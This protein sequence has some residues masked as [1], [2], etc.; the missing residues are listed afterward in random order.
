MSL[1]SSQPLSRCVLV[2]KVG[3]IAEDF[4]VVLSRT[5]HFLNR[6]SGFLKIRLATEILSEE[7]TK[8]EPISR[9]RQVRDSRNERNAFIRHHIQ[10][11]VIAI[12][13]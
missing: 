3:Q 5:V 8:R 10:V 4:A 2:V 9:R 1:T 12:D 11:T 7:R 13:F 6:F